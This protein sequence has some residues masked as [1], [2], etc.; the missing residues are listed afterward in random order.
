[1]THYTNTNNPIDFPETPQS[2]LK[3]VTG[4]LLQLG[5]NNEFDIIV[6]GCNCFNV[7]GAG[8]AAQIK[9]Q[10]PDAYLA[11]QETLAGDRNKLGCYTIGMAGRLVIINAYTQYG[12][13][14]YQGHDVFDY[15]AFEEILNKLLKR[16]GKYR[17]GLPMIGMGLAGGDKSVILEILDTF[18]TRVAAQGGVWLK[19]QIP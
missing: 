9:T 16:F 17:F 7:M 4:D 14:K 18:A 1:M 10:F 8:I 12:T 15:D 11:D 3:L 13:A 6:Q 2:D 5:K 19:W